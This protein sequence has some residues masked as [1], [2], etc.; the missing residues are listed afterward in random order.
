MFGDAQVCAGREPFRIS[1]SQEKRLFRGHFIE[2]PFGV[3]TRACAYKVGTD[4]VV[5]FTFHKP[6][7]AAA[8]AVA[9]RP[10]RGVLRVLD[11]RPV[12]DYH[13]AIRS[14]LVRAPGP[15]AQL[16][17]R[18][19]VAGGLDKQF[20]DRAQHKRTTPAKIPEDVKAC[21]RIAGPRAGVRPADALRFTAELSKTQARLSRATGIH[22]FD[23]FH[24]GNFSQD[25]QGRP[26]IIDLGASIIPDRALAKLSRQRTL[27]GAQSSSTALVV[28]GVVTTLAACGLAALHARA[29]G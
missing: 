25:A 22:W 20:V 26:V 21:I 10:V 24:P 27:E 15:V 28:V 4:E 14:K 3:G 9:Q 8:L 5:K 6:D 1:A 19:A 12:S 16:V 7:A 17:Q 23:V 29:G 13:F 2:A 18:C 11:V